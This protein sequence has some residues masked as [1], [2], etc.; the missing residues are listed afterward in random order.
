MIMNNSATIETRPD[1]DIVEDVKNI[2]AHYPPLVTDR[3]HIDITSHNGALVISGHVQSPINR[4]YLADRAQLISG[5]VSVDVDSLCDE[6]SIRFEV[7]NLI[8]EGVVAAVR[9]SVVILSGVVPED[10][11]EAALV[12]RIS[13]VK[14]VERVLTSFREA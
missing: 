1:I 8:P 13:A 9:Y 11:T 2:I 6:E 14:G 5:V 12:E 4:R 3:R 7:G 10:T